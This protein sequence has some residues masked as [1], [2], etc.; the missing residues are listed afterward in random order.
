MCMMIERQIHNET[1]RGDVRKINVRMSWK[2]WDSRVV[3]IEV[4]VYSLKEIEIK[5]ENIR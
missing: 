2:A 3:R 5:R 1:H 4:W